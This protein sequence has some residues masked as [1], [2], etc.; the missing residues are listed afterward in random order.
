MKTY[1]QLYFHLFRAL[2]RATEALEQ[3]DGRAALTLLVSAQ[4]E[5]EEACLEADILLDE[6]EENA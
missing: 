3:G 1:K 6:R 4:R 2:A 5:A